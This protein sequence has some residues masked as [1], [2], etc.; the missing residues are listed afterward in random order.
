MANN[1]TILGQSFD[2]YVDKQLSIRTRLLSSN[3]GN[4]NFSKD[5]ITRDLNSINYGI[6]KTA[7]IRL[8]SGVNIED[9]DFAIFLGSKNYKGNGLAKQ[10]ILQ[11]GTLNNGALRGGVSGPNSAYTVGNTGTL[12]EL[13]LRPMPGIVS[14]HVTSRGRWGSI[15]DVTINIKCYDRN[16]LSIIEV[17]YLRPGYTVLLEWGHSLFYD[18]NLKEVSNTSFL[19]FFSDGLTKDKIHQK[20]LDK[21]EQYAGNYDGF[22]GPVLNFNI[23]TNN[24]GTYDC[25]CRAITWGGIIESIKINT[26]APVSPKQDTSKTGP[27]TE[28]EMFSSTL[29]EETEDSKLEGVLNMI[30]NGCSRA[31]QGKDIGDIINLEGL[32]PKFVDTHITGHSINKNPTNIDQKA[33]STFSKVEFV[34]SSTN[35]PNDNLKTA[36]PNASYYMRL[37]TLL[38]IISKNCLLYSIPNS[39]EQIIKGVPAN[40][41]PI[42]NIDFNF[43]ENFCYSPENHISLDPSVCLIKYEGPV[44]PE[45]GLTRDNIINKFLPQFKVPNSKSL[46]GYTMNIMVNINYVLNRLSTLKD[47][48]GEINLHLF[49]TKLMQDISVALGKVNDFNIGVDNETNTLIISDNQ[50]L[51]NSPK[52][53]TVINTFGLRS[54]VRDINIDSKINNS[55]AS[56]IAIGAQASGDGAGLDASL[57]SSFNRGLKDRLVPNRVGAETTNNLTEQGYI[58]SLKNDSRA[59]AIKN[60]ITNIYNSAPAKLIR[61]DVETCKGFYADIIN[62]LRAK[63]PD[64]NSAS[65]IP[66]YFNLKMDGL[67]GIKYGQLFSIEPLRLPKNYFRGSNKLVP[68]VAFLVTSVNHDIQNNDWTTTIVGQMAPI[69]NVKIKV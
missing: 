3:P 16:Q 62:T 42:V 67:S 48:D 7:F 58:D 46:V 14:A 26:S 4:S 55:L 52:E 10:Y 35:N 64:K 21:R 61:S 13:G 41:E 15:R 17:L 18:N 43:D 20:I 1:K 63:N 19:D 44:F 66:F 5:N 9:D 32:S 24:D 60:C 59:Q 65:I 57:L 31:S 45:L 23:K 28:S 6:A 50:I 2:D 68:T 47:E 36:N 12:G 30:I 40:A 34:E 11:G 25:T 39:T 29:Q 51:G 8:T 37:G 54:V 33:L 38:S 22:V 56:M 69:R 53:L 49:L 27:P